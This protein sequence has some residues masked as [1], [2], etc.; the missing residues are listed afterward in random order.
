MDQCSVHEKQI[1]ELDN[2]HVVMAE[3]ANN[4]LWLTRIGKWALGV[5]GGVLLIAITAVSFFNSRIYDL[6]VSVKQ[7]EIRIANLIEGHDSRG[8]YK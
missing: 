4:V 1:A 7:S 5:C 8:D 3:I 6:T 2:M